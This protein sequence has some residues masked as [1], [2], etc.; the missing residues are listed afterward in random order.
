M[1]VCWSPRINAL[2]PSNSSPG[3]NSR[4][5]VF[6]LEG[7]ASES[8]LDLTALGS[9]AWSLT[10][11]FNI[12]VSGNMRA[13][14]AQNFRVLWE[15]GLDAQSTIDLDT[16]WTL[17]MGIENLISASTADVILPRTVR[18]GA[19]FKTSVTIAMDLIAATN[20]EPGLQLSA[21]ASLN[22][23]IN[24]RARV[25]SAPFIISLDVQLH[26]DDF[27]ITLLFDHHTAI[28]SSIG[29]VVELPFGDEGA[30]R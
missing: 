22:N 4:T 14:G 2:S 3:T 16:T 5:L 17:G 24:F 7:M 12:G 19:A 26:Q 9:H 29:C 23:N 28:G 20:A 6:A 13:F 1:V 10:D 21:L 18:I 8:W 15:G 25:L 27:V 11:K 30:S